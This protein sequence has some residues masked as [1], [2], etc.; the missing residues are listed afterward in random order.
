MDE[1][2]RLL[3]AYDSQ[4]RTDAETAGA[5]AVHTLGPLRLATFPGGRGVITYRDLDG[6]DADEVARWS[7]APWSTTTLDP[8]VTEVE[9]KARG[10]DVAPGCTVACW[11]TASGR[12]GVD[13]GRRAELLALDVALPPG[14][15]VRR[16]VD[17]PDVR[18]ASAAQDEAFGSGV[19]ARR[20]EDLLRR[21]DLDDGLELWVAEAAGHVVSAGRLEHVPGSDSPGCGVAR[22]CPRGVGAASTVR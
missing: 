19:S 20:A 3:A 2:A 17:E 13:H 14:V 5:L 22:P 12:A 9:W 10:H 6:A 7:T 4:L 1:T 8:G 16:V 21:L 11:S 18:A 15:M